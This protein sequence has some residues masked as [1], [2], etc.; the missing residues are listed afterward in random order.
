M[1][2]LLGI[3]IFTAI[4]YG[5]LIDGTFFKLYFI[6]L[7]IYHVFTQ[8]LSIDKKHCIKRKNITVTMWDA[9]SDPTSYIPFDLDCTNA[10]VYCKKLNEM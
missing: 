6:F 9:P 10:L 3:G 5:I 1:N 4:I 2:A 8:V 7:I